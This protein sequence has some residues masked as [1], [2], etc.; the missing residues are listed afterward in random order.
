MPLISPIITAIKSQSS[1]KCSSNIRASVTPYH[2]T[3]RL[4]TIGYRISTFPILCLKY[5]TPLPNK[6]NSSNTISSNIIVEVII[7]HR[8]GTIDPNTSLPD[9]I[10]RLNIVLV[11]LIG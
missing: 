11:I 5:V 7:Q 8:I 3:R 4:D 6:F 1:P 10:S 2:T 9:S